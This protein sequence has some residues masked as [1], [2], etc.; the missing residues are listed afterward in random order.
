MWNGVLLAIGAWVL[1]PLYLELIAFT[2]E[3][4]FLLAVYYT[5]DRIKNPWLYWLLTLTFL[6]GAL[7]SEALITSVNAWM[8]SPWG[9]GNLVQSIYPW[10]PV[11]GPSVSNIQFLVA[12]K[13][14]LVKINLQ[15]EAGSK[16]V[17]PMILDQ[18]T[19]KYGEL[20]TDP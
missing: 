3:G 2:L 7:L 15:G 6:F 5:W 13:E 20:L 17:T 10:A 1:I 16:L 11:Y 4:S 18:L 9:V 8:Q 19:E 14:A 12:L